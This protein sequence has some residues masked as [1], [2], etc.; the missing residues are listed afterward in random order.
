LKAWLKQGTDE[1]PTFDY[2]MGT[3][4]L[5]DNEINPGDADY[6]SAQYNQALTVYGLLASGVRSIEV[7]VS[8]IKR[9]FQFPPA[10]ENIDELMPYE[11]KVIST[12]S[13]RP[14]LGVIPEWL[15][16]MLNDAQ[17][18]SDDPDVPPAL[19]ARAEIV[20]HYG[21]LQKTTMMS[22]TSEGRIVA[23]QE[24]TFGLW[25]ADIYGPAY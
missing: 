18:N 17:F 7:P 16:F 12:D 15:D 25:A 14:F 4:Y 24:F 6:F 9:T 11:G 21:W 22:D 13:L 23:N 2:Y 5:A 3:G 10:Y 1:P 8:I 20:K 19:V